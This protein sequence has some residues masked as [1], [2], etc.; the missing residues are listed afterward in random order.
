M[1]VYKLVFVLIL[2]KATVK[3]KKCTLYNGTEINNGDNF[4]DGCRTCSCLNN[5]NVSCKPTLCPESSIIPSTAAASSTSPSNN[6]TTPSSSTSSTS[7][8]TGKTSTSAKSDAAF[9]DSSRATAAGVSV[10]VA[11]AVAAVVILF[12]LRKKKKV[13]FAVTKGSKLENPNDNHHISLAR[14]E[15]EPNAN[16]HSPLSLKELE[17]H[18]YSVIATGVI[19]TDGFEQ[20]K[21]AI[22]PETADVHGYFVLEEHKSGIGNGISINEIQP[23]LVLEKQGCQP[24][25]TT[26][27]NS[28][29]SSPINK[30][31]SLY[32]ENDNVDMYQEIDSNDTYADI[33]D[34]RQGNNDY[35]YTDKTFKDLKTDK[36]DNVYNHLNATGNEYDHLGKE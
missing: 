32:L 30:R 14:K 5:G 8:T 22:T 34:S 29:N 27:S 13:C 15:S 25:K 16:Y 18:R 33:D 35:D 4:N 1:Y 24:A 19:A 21:N 28:N 10:A 11:L 6:T 9:A 31:N 3:G 26:H 2:A 17:A 36:S 7:S 20:Q 23:S 12:F